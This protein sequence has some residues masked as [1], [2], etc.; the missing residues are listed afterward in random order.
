MYIILCYDVNVKRIAKTR[1][2]C[3]KYLNFSQRSVYEGNISI[4]NLNKLKRELKN[5][6]DTTNDEVIIYKMES[7]RFAEKEKIGNTINN[8]LIL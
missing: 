8:E 4:K 1:K 2:T 3:L 6:I 5:I 7:T